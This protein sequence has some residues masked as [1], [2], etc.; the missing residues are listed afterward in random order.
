MMDLWFIFIYFRL[1]LAHLLTLEVN[2]SLTKEDVGEHL[3][4]SVV[5]P[6]GSLPHGCF[7]LQSPVGP[8]LAASAVAVADKW[9]RTGIPDSTYPERVGIYNVTYSSSQPGPPGYGNNLVT[10]C[11]IVP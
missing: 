4:T 10:N 7:S 9:P 11:K 5:D 1:H 3:T 6:N 8:S 2:N